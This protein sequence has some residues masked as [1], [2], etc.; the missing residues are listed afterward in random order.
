MNKHFKYSLLTLVSAIVVLL[1]A[2]MS[3]VSFKIISS[4]LGILLMV[5]GTFGLIAFIVSAV[6]GYAPWDRE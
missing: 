1:G 5:Y 4:F 2:L 6:M 3:G